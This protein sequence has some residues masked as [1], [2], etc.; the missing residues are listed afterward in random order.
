M[1]FNFMSQTLPWETG[2]DLRCSCC[3]DHLSSGVAA[4]TGRKGVSSVPTFHVWALFQREMELQISTTQQDK[5]ERNTS[6][7]LNSALGWIGH[8]VTHL[9]LLVQ[10]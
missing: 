3:A 5:C 6:I 7:C 1:L 2:R 8:D 4:W 9:Q 10:K